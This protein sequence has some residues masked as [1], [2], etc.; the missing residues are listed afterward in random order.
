MKPISRRSFLL[1]ASAVSMASSL[2]AIDP[3]KRINPRIKGLSLTTYSL[4][5]KMRYWWGKKTKNGTLDTL[6]FLDYCAKIGLDGAEITS[7]FFENPVESSYIKKVKRRAHILGLDITGGAVGN[8]FS[9]P[10]NS[11][12]GKH[13]LEYFRSW[14]DHFSEM[15]APVV[16]IF[17][18]R[19]PPKGASPKQIIENVL[20]NLQEALPYAE[21]RGV[22]LGLENHDFVKNIDYLLEITKRVQSKWFGIIWDSANLAPTPDPYA[23]LARIAPYAITAQIKVMTKVDGKDVPAD[24][25]RLVKILRKADYAGHLVFEYEEPEDAF[26]EIPKH[27]EKLRKLID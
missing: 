1:T 27:I 7:Y 14:V 25:A 6:D 23:D 8:D 13:Q 22:M 11:D 19:K 10:P 20:A 16:R 2:K 4:K 12:R 21:K 3:F 5:P 18:A 9:H 24:Y 15:G 26:I 17:A